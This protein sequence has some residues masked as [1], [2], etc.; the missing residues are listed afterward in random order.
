[1]PRTH[2]PPLDLT[3]PRDLTAVLDGQQRLKSLNTA[4]RGSMAVR[5]KGKWKTNP[6]AY[7]VKRLHLNLS[8]PA[9]ENDQGR[10]YDFRFLTDEHAAAASVLYYPLPDVMTLKDSGP[11]IQKFLL[12][13]GLDDGA[14]EF[15]FDALYRLYEVAHKDAVVSH[16]LEKEQDLDRVLNIFIRVNSGATKLSYSDLLMSIAAA[17]W[18]GDDAREMVHGLVDEINDVGDGFDLGKDF[19]LKAGLTLSDIASVGF[20]VENFDAANMA[21]LKD[22]WPGV[23]DALLGTV[24]LATALGLDGRSLT[25]DSALLPIAYRLHRRGLGDT[26]LTATKHRDEREAISSFLRR[27]LLK[28]GVWGSGLDVTLT[29][30]REVLRSNDGDGFPADAMEAELARRGRSLRFGPEEIDELLDVVYG[31]KRVVPLLALLFPHVDLRNKFHVDHVFPKSRLTR[32][33]LEK[34]GFDRDEAERLAGQRDLL[35]NLQ[36]LDGTANVEK[37]NRPPHDWMEEHLPGTDARRAYTGRTPG[38][39]CSAYAGRSRGP[40]GVL[41]RPPRAVSERL[42]QRLSSDTAGST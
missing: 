18:T 35:P 29:A 12:K 13:H 1:M 30:L 25:A 11:S 42:T 4:F 10:R 26:L 14:M 5:E 39:T 2:C 23:R 20:K 9:E 34:T 40:C 28:S 3:T 15:A 27:S 17:Q 41:R 21:R 24:R 32:A 33:R 22:N 8:R 6:N 36:L 7:P 19:V 16:Y 38:F 37:S 31:D